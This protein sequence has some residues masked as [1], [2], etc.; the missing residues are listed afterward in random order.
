MRREPVIAAVPRQERNPPPGHLADHH[1]IAGHPE[2]SLDDDLVDGLEKLIQTRTADDANISQHS[3]SQPG[4]SRHRAGPVDHGRSGDLRARRG[5]G[6]WSR[7]RGG[8]RGRCRRGRAAASL[9]IAALVPLALR[10][11]PGVRARTRAAVAGLSVRRG[12]RGLGA[13][14]ALPAV[15]P[16]DTRPLYLTPYRRADPA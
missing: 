5:R 4:L 2:R 14:L 13:L 10:G 15:G 9:L 3:L 16:V 12:D 1:G 11:R 6:T 8:T 7:R